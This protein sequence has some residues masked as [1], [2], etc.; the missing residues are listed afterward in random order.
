MLECEESCGCLN[1]EK[2][3]VYKKCIFSEIFFV[4]YQLLETK[5]E[6]CVSKMMLPLDAVVHVNFPL[7]KSKKSPSVRKDLRISMQVL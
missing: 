7:K 2:C 5:L 3:Y 6:R 1:L 4:E